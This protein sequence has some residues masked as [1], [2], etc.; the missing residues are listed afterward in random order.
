MWTGVGVRGAEEGR[1]RGRVSNPPS[2]RGAS[3]ARE[4]GIHSPGPGDL[5]QAKSLSRPH[6]EEHRHRRA[7]AAMTG[8]SKERAARRHPSRLAA[9]AARTSG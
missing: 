3:E 4:P 8:V 6:P 9:S 1:A 2:F 5:R 7:R